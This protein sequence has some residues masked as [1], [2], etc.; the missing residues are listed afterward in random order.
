MTKA[1]EASYALYSDKVQPSP[2]FYPLTLTRYSPLENFRPEGCAGACFAVGC[3]AIP[4]FSSDGPP[5][6]RPH[7]RPSPGAAS[8]PR[9]RR[10]LR[11]LDCPD[12]HQRP[13]AAL[14][15]RGRLPGRALPDQSEARHGAG[16]DGLSRSRL[17]AG[18]GRMRGYRGTSEPRA[19]S[20]GEL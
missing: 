19:R 18:T 15:P 8:R 13:L 7:D 2:L 9:L 4:L 1:Q 16:A 12:A 20:H 11:R 6:F 14:L 5:E 3:G 10:D 17:G